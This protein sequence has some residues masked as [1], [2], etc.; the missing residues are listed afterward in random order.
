MIEITAMNENLTVP[1]GTTYGELSKKYKD[2]FVGPI[3][4]AKTGNTEGA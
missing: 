1:E 4:A 2:L 3:M